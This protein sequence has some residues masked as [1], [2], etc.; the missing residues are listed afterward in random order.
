MIPWNK[1]GAFSKLLFGIFITEADTGDIGGTQTG[2]G[3]SKTLSA[4]IDST[5][6]FCWRAMV[7]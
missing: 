4:V 1:Q 5:S 2:Q 3:A 7:C 6:F